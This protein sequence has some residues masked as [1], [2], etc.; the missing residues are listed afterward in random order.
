MLVLL[1][2]FI[3][4]RII[5][6]E[7]VFHSRE[8]FLDANKSFEFHI[9]CSLF[10]DAAKCDAV[11]DDLE[12]VGAYIG[13]EIYFN[14]PVSVCVDFSNHTLPTDT[15]MLHSKH[16]ANTTMRRMASKICLK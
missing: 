7:P 11:T 13:R 3:I 16:I 15:D 12:N 14:V 2:S 9:D 6:F 1:L 8:G 10:E 5:A 4:P